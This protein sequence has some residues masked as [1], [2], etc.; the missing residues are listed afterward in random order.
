[1]ATKK[2]VAVSD[3]SPDVTPGLHIT[4]DRNVLLK[5]LTATTKV[6]AT[7]NTYPILANVLLTATADSLSVRATDLDIEITTT[8]PAVCNPG[9]ITVPAKT[10]FEIVRK[11]ADGA[12]VTLSMAPSTDA[13]DADKLIVKSGR[14]RFQ[15]ATLSPD[16]FPSL[17]SGNYGP[18]QDIDLAALFAPVAFAISNDSTRYYL[19]GIFLHSVDGKARAVATD[20]HRLARHDGQAFEASQGIIVSTGTVSVLAA[21]AGP[22]SLE[23]SNDANKI[24]VTHGDTVVVSKLIEGTF[25]DYDRVTPKNNDKTLTLERSAFAAAVDRV[26]V[27]ASERGGKAVKID[28]APGQVAL[29]VQNPDH[30][31]ATEEMPADTALEFEVGYNA[32]Y[33]SE[34]L[35]II[36]GGAVTFHWGDPMAPAVLTGENDNWI[37]VLMPQR[38]A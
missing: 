25:P 33:L 22:V 17:D 32:D 13:R 1:M 29:T 18:A 35:R 36:G 4:I 10:L 15:L 6:V 5:A 9:V 2:P 11:F 12:E 20:G 23:V 16:T 19:N 21:M 38:V 28:V 24:R 26:G 31:A 3:A 8:V 37:G 7:R 27:I 14:S 34:M 30:G